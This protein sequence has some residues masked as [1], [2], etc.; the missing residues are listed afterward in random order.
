MTPVTAGLGIRTED[1]L[2]C[3]KHK[4]HAVFLL[5]TVFLKRDLNKNRTKI[6]ELVEE[7]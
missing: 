7:G 6:E 3:Q 4:A 2:V 5:S 1:F